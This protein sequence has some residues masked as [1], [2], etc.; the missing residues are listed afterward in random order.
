MRTGKKIMVL[1]EIDMGLPLS[2]NDR[3]VIELLKLVVRVAPAG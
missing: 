3:Q 1:D 2:D